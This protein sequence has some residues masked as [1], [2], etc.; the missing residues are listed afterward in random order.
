MNRNNEMRIAAKLAKSKHRRRQRCQPL[1]QR[2]RQCRIA[3]GPGA[4]Q[5]YH[6]GRGIVRQNRGKAARA[7]LG[8]PYHDQASLRGAS[9]DC[10]G[11]ARSVWREVVGPELFPIP[12]YSRDWGE[13][14]AHEV[15]AAGARAIMLE[16]PLGK[17]THFDINKLGRFD[18]PGHRV[19]GTCIDC[20][21]RGRAGTA[22]MWPSMM[23]PGWPMSLFSPTSASTPPPASCCAP[24]AGSGAR[25]SGRN[26]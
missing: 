11:L 6:L 15:L 3:R 8:T 19:T 23:R 21:N 25:A 14:G 7:W 22:S 17:L 10:L 26:G 1:M 9:C 20:R 2:Q 5:R 13:T 4:I 12:P 16:I 24:G 18:Q